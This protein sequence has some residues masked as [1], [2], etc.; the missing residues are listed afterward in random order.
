[1]RLFLSNFYTNFSIKRTFPGSILFG[2]AIII[3][4]H[5]PLMFLALFGG[6]TLSSFVRSS[7]GLPLARLLLVTPPS[8]GATIGLPTS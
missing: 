8:F 1:M 4:L 3:P 6:G 7:R 2:G 5:K